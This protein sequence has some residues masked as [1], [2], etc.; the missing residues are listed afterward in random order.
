MSKNVL[1]L[2]TGGLDSTYLL[3]KNIKEGNDIDCLYCEILNNG[4]K[5]LV[6][7]FCADRLISMIKADETDRKSYIRTLTNKVYFSGNCPTNPQILINLFNSLMLSIGNND[8]DEVQI[9][10]VQGDIALSYINDMQ[11]LFN[12]TK[13]LFGLAN[14]KTKLTFPLAKEHKGDFIDK[15]PKKYFKYINSCENLAY[16]QE[17]TCVIDFEKIDLNSICGC[18][19][20]NLTLYKHHGFKSA[21]LL[22]NKQIV[23]EDGHIID[24]KTTREIIAQDGMYGV[25]S[26]EPA[27]V[28]TSDMVNDVKNMDMVEEIYLK[29]DE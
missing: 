12:L 5:T 1:L 11:K 14:N 3:L 16:R 7:K 8:Y 9:A 17:H 27:M 20:T 25:L 29:K 22:L 4:D 2:F 13:K 21:K 15:I 23:R 24:I 28:F 18:C 10:Y 19:V 6:E 26:D